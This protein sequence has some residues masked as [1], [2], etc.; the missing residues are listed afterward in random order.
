MKQRKEYVP[1]AAEVLLLAPSE[2]LAA[3]DW[4]F[5]TLW[6]REAGYHPGAEGLASAIVV[7]GQF[8]TEDYTEDSGFFIKK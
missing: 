7:T 2:K 4:G 3:W 1:P 8:G 6:K 5:D